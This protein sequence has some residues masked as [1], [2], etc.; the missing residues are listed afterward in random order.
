M[1]AAAAASS[2]VAAGSDPSPV[3]PSGAAQP[4]SSAPPA[5]DFWNPAQYLLYDELRARPS[6][7]LLRRAQD[8]LKMFHL[9]SPERVADLGCGPGKQVLQLARA[10]PS[11]NVLGVDSSANMIAAA[12]ANTDKIGEAAL[13]DRVRFA[14]ASFEEFSSSPGAPLDL[15][16]SN[17]AL[18]WSSSPH[19]SLFPHLLRQL[20]PNG[21]LLAVQMPNCFRAPS[22][23]CIRQAL[24][25]GSFLQDQE[26]RERALA[27]G[28]DVEDGGAAHYWHLLAPHCRHVDAWGT[29]YQQL[30]GSSSE[31]H[32]VSEWTRSTALAPVLSSLPSE[33]ERARFM[34]EYSALLEQH[35]PSFERQGQRMSLFPLKRIFFV[36]VR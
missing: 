25:Q 11:A 29:E 34:R 36:A 12:R 3:A 19:A 17:A 2:T 21:G 6:V 31:Y 18:H 26:E 32:P 24:E 35:Y 14:Q 23:T 8:T 1:S 15:L 10:F 22:H 7:E 20:R 27:Q 30:I 4:D 33:A 28:P 9:S 16:F 5:D 13:S